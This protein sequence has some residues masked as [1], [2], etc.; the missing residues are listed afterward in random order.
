[1]N[2]KSMKAVI[3]SAVVLIAAQTASART[4][5]NLNLNIGTPPV[6]VVA[7]PPPPVYAEPPQVVIET[8]PRFIFSPSLGF[9]VSIDI[10]YDIVF[11][12]GSYFMYNNGNWYL[13]SHVR[14][15]WSYVEYRRLPPRLIKFKYDK[16]RKYRD[17]EYRVYTRDRDNYRGRWHRPEGE[18]REIR[19]EHS[20]EGR[21]EERRDERR[22]DRY[23]EHRGE[24]H[25]GHG[26]DRH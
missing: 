16:I 7:P 18:W 24:H 26:G 9:Y 14:G 8:Q 21:R 23:E 10:P 19:H 15:P 17:R 11:V 12:D 3:V 20:P 25:E 22:E 13:S 2:G 5:V 1:M 4:D 6:T